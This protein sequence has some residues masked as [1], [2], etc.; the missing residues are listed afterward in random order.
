MW[1]KA[2]VRIGLA[3]LGS[4]VLAFA[5]LEGLH[6]WLVATDLEHAGPPV[7]GAVVETIPHAARAR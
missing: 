3:C 2:I 5:V 4:L 1:V 7:A 6:R